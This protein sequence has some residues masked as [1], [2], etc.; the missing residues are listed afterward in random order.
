MAATCGAP[1]RVCGGNRSGNNRE[2]A[3]FTRVIDDVEHY[4]RGKSAG[5]SDDTAGKSYS[6][7][8]PGTAAAF[9]IAGWMAAWDAPAHRC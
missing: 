3:E 8:Y 5:A 1:A 2:R 9:F 7:A 4:R 6:E